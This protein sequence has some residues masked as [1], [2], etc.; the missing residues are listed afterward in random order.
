MKR[1]RYIIAYVLLAFCFIKH[2]VVGQN[3]SFTGTVT[4]H[5]VRLEQVGDSLYIEMDMVLEDVKMNTSR[6]ADWIPQLVSASCTLNLP[7]ISL[8][9]RDEYKAY[10]RYLTLMTNR[11]K[12]SYDF[13]YIVKKIVGRKNAMISYQYHLP[14][15]TWMADACLNIRRDECGCGETAWMEIE[16]LMEKVT[17]EYPLIPYVITPHLAYIRPVVEQVKQRDV[18][19]ECFL[20]FEVNK[21]DIRPEYMNNPQELAKLRAM[22]DELKADADIQVK[23]LDIIGYASPEGSLA[24]NKRLSEGRA[25][26][27]GDYLA[28]LYDFPRSQYNIL[29]GGENWAGLV[30]TLQ[31]TNIDYRKELLNMITNNPYDQTLKLK[32]REFRGGIPYQ[33]LLRSVYPKL[34]VAI[35]KVNYEVKNFKVDEAREVFKKRP[36]NL[37]LNEMFLVANSYP[38]N[39][40]EFLEVFETAA[41][42]YP[43]DEV[44]GINAAVASLSRNDL[45]SAERYL[46]RVNLKRNQPVY[47][48]AMGVWM[49]LKGDD[50]S[51]EKYFKNAADSGLDAAKKNLLELAEKKSDVIKME[52]RRDK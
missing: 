11:E 2:P 5:P 47:D 17:L 1:N 12:A 40:L 48:N 22:I 15:E 41:R 30:K 45:V 42:M 32:L 34:R 6:G 36:Q 46:K 29:F 3:R 33:Y 18:Q 23:S 28:G 20:D 21:V 49:L 16:P 24:N 38:E 14:Y 37:S 39:S 13:P 4:I 51:A 8:K 44:A 31:H 9:G 35:C 26:A 43:E 50:E 52:Q 27:L 7:R 10:E 25:L 19:A